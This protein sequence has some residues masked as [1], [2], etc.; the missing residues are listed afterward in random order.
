[1]VLHLMLAAALAAGDV[2]RRVNGL[3]ARMTL[4]EKIGQTVQDSS[5]PSSAAESQ[6]ASDRKIAQAFL[7]DTKFRHRLTRLR[8]RAV[9]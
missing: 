3:L 4:D 5:G 2:E 8:Q 9:Y 1:M 6:D 7:A